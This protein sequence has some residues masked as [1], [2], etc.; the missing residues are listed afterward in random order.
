MNICHFSLNRGGIITQDVVE[1]TKE[2]L[3]E[4]IF[5]ARR[6]FFAVPPPVETRELNADSRRRK[7]APKGIG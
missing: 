3:N 2:A 6:I 1:L 5:G 4:R 7:R